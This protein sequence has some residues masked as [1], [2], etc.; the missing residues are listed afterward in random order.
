[1]T[2]LSGYYKAATPGIDDNTVPG[3]LITTSVNLANANITGLEGL[4]EWH[5]QES[6]LSGYGNLSISGASVGRPRSVQLRV[7][8]HF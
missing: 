8:V 3:S 6:P 2:K 1:M 4:V 5:P 7:N